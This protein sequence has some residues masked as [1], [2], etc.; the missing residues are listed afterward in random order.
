MR[1]GER[2]ETKDERKT[3]VSFWSEAIESMHLRVI[4]SPF[5]KLRVN[6]VEGSTRIV[7]PDLIGNLLFRLSSWNGVI[8]SREVDL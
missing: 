5:D 6:S 3:N 1:L 2:R 8:G 4:L 7:I